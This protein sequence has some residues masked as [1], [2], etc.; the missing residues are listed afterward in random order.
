VAVD[1]VEGKD[2]SESMARCD[3]DGFDVLFGSERDIWLQVRPL[4]GRFDAG[5]QAFVVANE[6]IAVCIGPFNGVVLFQ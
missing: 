4:D 3:D 2:P 1:V 6:F 5:K